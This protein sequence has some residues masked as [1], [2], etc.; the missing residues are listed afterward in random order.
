MGR[1]A[2]ARC[3]REPAPRAS[4]CPSGGPRPVFA[5]APSSPARA[6]AT[7][8]WRAARSGPTSRRRGARC[9]ARRSPA[10]PRRARGR[11]IV[12]SSPQREAPRTRRG[13]AGVRR[14]PRAGGRRRRARRLRAPAGARPPARE[15]AWPS[16]AAPGAHPRAAAPRARPTCCWRACTTACRAP[17]R[18]SGPPRGP[19]TAARPWWTRGRASCCEAH[20]GCMRA[21]R[22]P[23]GGGAF[24]P[25][26]MLPFPECAAHGC[27][28][29]CV[30]ERGLQSGAP[31]YRRSG[32]GSPPVQPGPR[33]PSGGASR[34]RHLH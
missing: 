7:C 19:G 23:V 10:T 5:Q 24:Q 28:S 22:A 32:A 30:T 8:A 13:R 27:W 14:R 6:C 20:G 21:G 1:H 9:R 15:H 33:L 16:P 26:G 18:A 4:P 29:P 11:S 3:A 17:R 2:V 25:C 12:K 31:S 34:G